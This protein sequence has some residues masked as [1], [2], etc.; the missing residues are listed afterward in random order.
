MLLYLIKSGL[1]LAIVLGTYL[2]LFEDKKMHRFNRWFLLLGLFFS[3]TVPLIET[4]FAIDLFSFAGPLESTSTTIEITDDVLHP[5]V[6][7]ATIEKNTLNRN[8][9]FLITY[10][11]ISTLLFIRFCFNITVLLQKALHN[12][13]VAFKGVK[14]VLLKEQIL[15]HTFGKYIFIN[16]SD[17][18]NKKI[19]AALFTHELT[20][21]RQWHSFDIIVIEFL[22]VLIWCNP[23]LIPYKRAIQLNH[24]FL[25]DE[26]VIKSH[27]RVRDYQNLL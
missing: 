23:F 4:A 20:H 17:Y 11:F 8:Q 5:A 25:A 16:K 27:R 6:E 12:K 24:E 3:F 1:C 9:L 21:A 22:Q 19:E 18:Q 15:P 13:Q 10:L 26:Q 7:A 2:L 14:L